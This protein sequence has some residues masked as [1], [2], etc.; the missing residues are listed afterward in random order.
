MTLTLPSS[1]ES[2]LTD[3]ARKEGI[4]PSELA[5]RMI[6]SAL[7][8]ADLPEDDTAAIEEGIRACLEG[9][10]RPFEEFVAEH[11]SKYRASS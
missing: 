7:D 4:E 11:R 3:R 8:W 2:R 6:T 1:T 5:D 9:R 10:V